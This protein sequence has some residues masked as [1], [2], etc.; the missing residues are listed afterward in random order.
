M[1][2]RK[3]LPKTELSLQPTAKVTD[4]PNRLECIESRPDI[5]ALEVWLRNE[6][7]LGFSK[8]VCFHDLNIP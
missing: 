6:I 1:P 7:Y 3:I 8:Y 4:I 2:V 5:H